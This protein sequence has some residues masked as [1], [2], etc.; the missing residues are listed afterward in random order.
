MKSAI[1]LIV[2]SSVTASGGMRTPKSSEIRRTMVNALSDSPPRSKKLTSGPTR[3]GSTLSTSTHTSVS[4]SATRSPGTVTGAAWQAA[5]G[6]P[7]AGT[8][9][10]RSAASATDAPPGAAVA[11]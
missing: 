10:P 4:R 1:C 8:A 3:A 5:V 9:A 11:R 6:R 2:T 7:G